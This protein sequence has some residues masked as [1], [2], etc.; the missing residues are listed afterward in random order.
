MARRSTLSARWKNRQLRRW[1][2]HRRNMRK[3]VECRRYCDFEVVLVFKPVM[4][5]RPHISRPRPNI[6]THSAH[7]T[8]LTKCC[9]TQAVSWIST[10]FQ[11][12][13]YLNSVSVPIRNTKQQL[14][15]SSVQCRPKL[16][17][18]FSRPQFTRPRPAICGLRPRPRPNITGLSRPHM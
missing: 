16:S 8:E 18:A 10:W 6:I 9:A 14:A 12:T 4:L 15:R 7:V 1:Q 11:T 3:Y 17:K 2:Q 13:R 5:T